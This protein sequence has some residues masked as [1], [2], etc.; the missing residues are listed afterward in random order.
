MCRWPTR[1]TTCRRSSWRRCTACQACGSNGKQRPMAGI[2]ATAV[3]D[4]A[5][6]AIAGMFAIAAGSFAA[7]L[8]GPDTETRILARQQALDAPQLWRV[9]A[10]APADAVKASV[11]ICADTAV[12]ESFTRTRAEVNG[13]TCKDT[14]PPVLKDNGWALRCQAHGWPF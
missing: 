3:F 7:G 6:L 5:V 4:R 2:L 11:F 10:L 9:D 14:T 1:S 13:E 8:E 12:R